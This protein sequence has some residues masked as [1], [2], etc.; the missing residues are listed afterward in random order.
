MIYLKVYVDEMSCEDQ[1][2]ITQSMYPDIPDSLVRQM[3]LICR[4]VTTTVSY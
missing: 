3:V 1:Q 4:Q 2:F